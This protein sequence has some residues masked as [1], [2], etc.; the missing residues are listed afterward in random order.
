MASLCFDLMEKQPIVNRSTFQ[1]NYRQVSIDERYNEYARARKD[2]EG[3]R[4][5]EAQF[6]YKP[7]NIVEL[8]EVFAPIAAVQEQNITAQNVKMILAAKEII[9]D[10]I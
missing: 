7:K 8:E 2:P 10:R 9:Q 5:Y 6:I 3:V 4:K 1:D